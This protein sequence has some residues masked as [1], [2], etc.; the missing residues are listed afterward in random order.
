MRKVMLTFLFVPGAC[1][2]GGCQADFA[3]DIRNETPQP[4]FAQIFMKSN[5]GKSSVMGASK[6]FGPGD[7]GFIGPVRTNKDAGAF[8]VVDTLP[9]P[10]TPITYDLPPG[11][12]FLAVEQIGAAAAGPLRLRDRSVYQTSGEQTKSEPLPADAVDV[13]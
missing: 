3:A 5:D 8:L 1:W 11:V 10:T 4:V 7:R 9:N 12:S 6:R 2:L 13:R